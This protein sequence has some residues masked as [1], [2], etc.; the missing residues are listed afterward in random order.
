MVAVKEID[1]RPFQPYIQDNVKV[2]ITGGLVSTKGRLELSIK[3]PQGL[4]AKFTGESNLAKFGPL[5]RRLPTN[6]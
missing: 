1:V 5:K 2:T 6:S 3:E 4:Q